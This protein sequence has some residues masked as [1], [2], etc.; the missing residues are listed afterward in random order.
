MKRYL[1][2]IGI[3]LLVSFSVWAGVWT[4]GGGASGPDSVGTS[5]LKD[6]ADV[7]AEGECL[8]VAADTGEIQYATC[9]GGGANSFETWTDGV[10][11]AVADASTDIMTANDSSTINVVTADGPETIVWNVIANSITPTELDL[12]ME[13]TMTGL[14]TFTR[15]NGNLAIDVVGS[16]AGRS[17]KIRFVPFDDTGPQNGTMFVGSTGAW[18]L[19]N[20]GSFLAI[21]AEINAGVGGRHFKVMDGVMIIGDNTDVTRTLQFDRLAA[22][23]NIGYDGTDF[24]FNDAITVSGAGNN[25]LVTDGQILIGDNT[26]VNRIIRF[27]HLTA[28]GIFLFNGGAFD[29]NDDIILSGAGNRVD[30]VDLAAH[31]HDGTG[32]Q[33]VLMPSFSTIGLA[34]AD[35][36][37]DT[38]PVTDGATIDFTTTDNPEGFTAEV[39][40]DSIRTTHLS[41]GGSVPVTGECLLVGADINDVNFAACPGG[42][43]ADSLTFLEVDYTD[44]DD[45]NPAT[46]EDE[47]FWYDGSAGAGNGGWACEGT[48]NGF[49]TFFQV[50]DATADRTIT[51]PNNSGSVNLS[52]TSF[53]GD[54]IGTI[55]VTVVNDVTCAGSCISDA[56]VDNALTV[57]LDDASTLPETDTPTDAGAEVRVA[58]TSGGFFWFG[59]GA[60][61][62]AATQAELD[63]KLNLSG[64]TMTGALVADEQGLEF[65]ESDDAVTCTTGDYWIRAD[66]SE[67]TLKKCLDGAETVLDTTGGTPAFSDITGATNSTAAMIVG[68]GASLVASG[69]G[70][71]RATDLDADAIDALTELDPTLCAASQILE[72]QGSVWACIT[73]PSGGAEINDLS[74]AVTWINVPDANVVGSA[75]RDEVCGTTSLSSTCEINANVVSFAEMTDNTLR[76]TSVNYDWIGLPSDDP[77]LATQDCYWTDGDAGNSGIVCEGQTADL[78]ETHISITDPTG[79]DKTFLIPDANTIAPQAITCTGT[80]KFSVLNATTG[81]ITCSPDD[82]TAE[83]DAKVSNDLTH[84]TGSIALTTVTLTGIE[85]EG[86]LVGTGTGTAAFSTMPNCVAGNVLTYTA[87]SNTFGCEAD[88]GGAETNTLT[89]LTTG[90]ATG[91]IPIGTT[92]GEA[93]AYVTLQPCAFDEKLEYTDAAPDTMTCEQ[94][95]GLIDADISDTL[96]ASQINSTVFSG[97]A[98]DHAVLVGT[99]SNTIGYT[100][101]IPNCV[102]GNVLTFTQAGN[103]WGCELDADS[104][105]APAFTDITG[106]TNITA[107][108]DVGTG[109]SLVASGSGTIEANLVNCSGCV[110]VVNI[111][112]NTT[113]AS[114]VNYVDLPDTDPVLGE[115]ECFWTNGPT[116]AGNGGWVCE[117]TTNTIETFFVVADATSA[118]KTVTFADLSGTVIL[119][120]AVQIITGQKT[121]NSDSLTVTAGNWSN[122]AHAH[123]TDNGGQLTNTGITANTIRG[124]E[125]VDTY[126]GRSLSENTN[127]LDLDVEIFTRSK[128]FGI[129]DP[130]TGDSGKVQWAP[131]LPITITKVWCSTLPAT[132]TVTIMPDER[133]EG[134]PNTGGTDILSA[135]LVCD[136]G[137]QSSC[138]SGCTVNTIS[139]ATIDAYDP[140]SWDIDATG[141]ATPTMVRVH[142]E[143]TVND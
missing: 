61:H 55:A 132:A 115:D 16:D 45:T 112:N 32:G 139:N 93:A 143:Y 41:D 65:L 121:F 118:D 34:I 130:V 17:P 49:E 56:E 47:C 64:G 91:E 129:F 57:D 108:M 101:A 53:A 38:L 116:G 109:S 84:A 128:S 72:R 25:L 43:S 74:A 10:T 114:L 85:N 31:D 66:L 69:S 48:V 79:A 122:A 100:A 113:T 123:T 105:G 29:F 94:I 76:N 126:A 1:P 67:T 8:K 21:I 95:S 6:G 28:D 44:L 27:D 125:I 7:P 142:V 39:I 102:A 110:S 88:A 62:E 131:P 73:T 24:D 103:T 30:G 20:E 127:V 77:T 51:F 119:D 23:G 26:A 111:A 117:G 11:A 124:N 60:E 137:S 141:G 14:W 40:V 136:D 22:D 18:A 78:I 140:V 5:E 81:L 9:G 96:T 12:A 70:T 138:A 13:P 3:L 133:A 99:G 37:G 107:A 36:S 50:A 83:T 68:T 71:V 106:G 58:A 135:G 54:V 134:T 19:E 52:S 120:A 98:I 46:G 87:A 86:V 4:V 42:V 59:N 15:T 2:L 90:I 63:T 92:A 97:D 75:E 89:T 33:G 104:G 80:D 35:I 82:D